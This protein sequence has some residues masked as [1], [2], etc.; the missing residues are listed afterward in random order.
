MN[1]R[2]EWRNTHSQHTGQ[3]SRW[4]RRQGRPQFPK[5]TSG[6]SPSSGGGSSDWVSNQSSWHSTIMRVSGES[7]QPAWPGRGLRVKVSLW[8]FKDKKTKD[9]VTYCSWQWYIAIFHCW[10]RDTSICCCMSS[11]HCRGSWETRPGV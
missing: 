7:N 6:G 9:A 4:H 10:G 5:D 1:H 11:D 2:P 8:I 3:G